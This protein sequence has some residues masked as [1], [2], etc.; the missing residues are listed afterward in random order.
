MSTQKSLPCRRLL[1]IWGGL[2][3]LL[4]PGLVN[5]QETLPGHVSLRELELEPRAQGLR[6][7][8]SLFAITAIAELECNRHAPH[9]RLSE[10]FLIWAGN[11]ASGL[12]GDQAMFYK[13]V[14]GLNTFGICAEEWMP[15]A[16][17]SDP[18]RRPTPRALA[19]AKERSG[20]WKV[21]WIRRWDVKD[22]LT[23]KELLAIKQALANGHPVACGFRWPKKMKGHEILAV[24]PPANVF[25]GH[26][27]A[28]VGYDDDPQKNGGGVFRFRNS[29]GPLWGDNGHG[30]ICYAYVLA[31]LNDAL[32]LKYEP[33]FSEVPA[34]RF[35][36]ES[37][38]VLAS[39]K[40]ATSVQ[41]MDDW[42]PRMWSR[43]PSCFARQTR[44]DS[45]SWS[46][47]S[48]NPA[49][50]VSASWPRRRR[51]SAEFTWP[52]TEARWLLSSISTAAKC[53]LRVPWNWART[54]SLPGRTG[55]VSRPAGKTPLRQTFSSAST[56]S[57]SSPSGDNVAR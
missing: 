19:D 47:W 29:N 31:Y 26:S 25:D 14:H 40:C 51:T 46:S 43:A 12:K 45:S 56:L 57:I 1:T 5:G 36:A 37:I 13:A 44:G 18:E 22:T 50:I 27:V 39:K 23:Q 48:P 15:Y 6:D 17:K 11:E 20:R 3:A 38:R 33:P 52:S 35:E 9:H 10:E 54:S 7:T 55:Y 32:W 30:T 49:P 53:R 8:C 16:D 21:H 41:K 28:L 24:P 42:G 34:Q 4:V 2:L